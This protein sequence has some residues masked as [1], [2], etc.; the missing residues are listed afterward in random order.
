MKEETLASGMRVWSAHPGGAGPFPSAIIF[1][2]RRGPVAHTFRMA[3]RMT[4]EGFAA[5]VPD[6]FHRYTEP[7][8]PVEA[9]EIRVEMPDEET[10]TDYDELVGYID[11][12][13][14]AD[15]DRLVAAGFCQTG[16]TPLVIASHRTNLSGAIVF[17]GGIYP[18]DFEAVGRGEEAVTGLVKRVTCP[19]LGAFGE[20]DELVP[21]PNVWAF[22]DMLEQNRKSFQIR[23]FPDTPHSWMDASN[24]R[25]REE[26]AAQAWQ[27][28]GEFSRAV[29]S[30]AWKRDQLIFR[31]ESGIKADQTFLP[32]AS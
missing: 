25:Y 1:H 8:G 28:L 9:A 16:R 7:R 30:D 18:R 20:L 5:F 12:L 3:E 26:A 17:H 13:S 22:R 31:F 4:Q 2:E 23:L 32:A 11:T 10:L 29:T 21:L 19:V 15:A 14:F 24:E 27:L 6:F